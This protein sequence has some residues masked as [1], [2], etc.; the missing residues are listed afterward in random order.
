MSAPLAYYNEIDP[1]AAHVLRTL[2]GAGVIAPGEVDTRSIRFLGQVLPECSASDHGVRGRSG[3]EPTHL[4]ATGC[5]SLCVSRQTSENL[6][7]A[8]DQ[9]RALPRR[10]RMRAGHL[11]KRGKNAQTP[12]LGNAFPWFWRDKLPLV[13][14]AVCGILELI[15]RCL[16]YGKGLSRAIYCTAPDQLQ[17]SSRTFGN[18]GQ[19]QLSLL[20]RS[21]GATLCILL[22][23]I[24]G[25]TATPAVRFRIQRTWVEIL[26]RL[27]STCSEAR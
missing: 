2:I 23:N 9:V 14:A 7:Y 22:S 1:A 15:W 21:C 13:E 3:K 16:P 6:A 24:F 5:F 4:R 19:H 10:I 11:D 26:P 18:C 12:Y 27:R 25:E 8:L 17:T 20:R